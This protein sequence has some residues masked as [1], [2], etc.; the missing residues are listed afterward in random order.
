MTLV[1]AEEASNRNYLGFQVS[2][3]RGHG[4]LGKEPIGADRKCAEALDR[5]IPRD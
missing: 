3:P 5:I 1:L 2:S 4:E